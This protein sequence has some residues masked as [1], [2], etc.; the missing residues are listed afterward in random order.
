MMLKTFHQK[1][2]TQEILNFC[3]MVL[4][5]LNHSLLGDTHCTAALILVSFDK[6]VLPK[7]AVLRSHLNDYV[8]C[9]LL[10][11]I[12]ALMSEVHLFLFFMARQA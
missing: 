11:P 5:I 8:T 6:N 3:F 9:K 10:A 7:A 2:Y 1:S 12:I 4:N